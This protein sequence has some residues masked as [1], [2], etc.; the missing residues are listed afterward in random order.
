MTIFS[1]YPEKT[2]KQ[3]IDDVKNAANLLVMSHSNQ[4]NAANSKIIQGIIDFHDVGKA[5]KFF[6]EYIKNPEIYEGDS[7]KKEHSRLSSLVACLFFLNKSKSWQDVFTIFQVISGHHSNLRTLQE[8]SEYWSNSQKVNILSEQLYCLPV[9]DVEKEIDLPITTL[10]LKKYCWDELVD[11]LEEIQDRIEKLS[12]NDAL[13]FR[14]NLQFVYSILL[15]SDKAFLAVEDHKILLFQKGHSWELDWINSFIG[16]NEKGAVNDLRKTVRKQVLENSYHTKS[17]INTLTAPTGVGKT[18]LSISWAIIQRN[19]IEKEFRIIP[20]IIIVLPFLSIITQTVDTYKKVLENSGINVDGS[21]LLASHSLSDGKYNNSMQEQE[22]R[23]FID[24]WKSDLIITTYDQFLYAIFDPKSKYQ[25]RF[26]NI[27]D[28]IVIFDEV[29]SIPPKLWEPFSRI[30]NAI[31]EI[32]SSKFLL[33]SATLPAFVSNTESLLP[34]YDAIYKKLNRYKIDVSEIKSNSIISLEELS[35]KL[36]RELDSWLENNDRVLITL[37]TRKSAKVVFENL[38]K[39]L[40]NRKLNYPMFFISSDVIPLDRLEKI[41]SIKK[42]NPCI[43]VSTQSIE[44]GVD[45]DMD[46]VYRDF[47]PIDSLVQ[48][49]GRCNRNGLKEQKMVKIFQIKSKNGKLFSELIYDEIC[50]QKSRQTIK[51]YM[52]DYIDEKN[53]LE[54]TGKYFSYLLKNDGVNTGMEN[55]KD[56]A[57]WKECE[58]IKVLLRGKET[59]NYEFILIEK[60]P[61][62]KKELKEICEIDNRW[63]KREK[64]KRISSK[65]AELTVSV[66]AHRNFDPEEI[67]EKY[68]G[69][70]MLRSCYYDKN[71]GICPPDTKNGCLII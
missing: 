28:S 33:M 52:M 65:L 44:A 2:L 29:Q 24:T 12:L 71:T 64:L 22:E 63:E 32:S 68:Y 59:E 37:N 36:L 14:F 11:F 38:Y 10:N 51:E 56:F 54:I 43:V 67:S 15:E 57:Y 47:S 70:N 25:M 19:K 48:I 41:E 20:K 27:L 7:E 46:K 16:S 55:I 1:H 23:F 60:N 6:Q 3:H 69:M 13:F 4:L 45:I 30:L 50:L 58:S 21:W 39:T 35:E 62:L 18:L 31:S 61:S 17:S 66:I 9:N 53:I 34:K 8:V 5:S 49:A 40:E 42:G 26:H